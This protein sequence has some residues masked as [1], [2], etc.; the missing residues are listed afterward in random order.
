MAGTGQ[1]IHYRTAPG[2]LKV[3]TGP[4]AAALKPFIPNGSANRGGGRG[5]D[6]PRAAGLRAAAR[7]VESLRRGPGR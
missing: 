1:Q 7:T 3:E 6:R 2:R 4:Q 5:A